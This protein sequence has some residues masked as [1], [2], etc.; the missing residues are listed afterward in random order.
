MGQDYY[1]VLGVGRDATDDQIKKAYKRKALQFH[2]DKNKAEDSEEKFKKI[3]EAYE[4]LSDTNKRSVY[5][6]YGEQGL[7]QHGSRNGTYTNSTFHPSDPFD[8]FRRFFGD[9]D[10]FRDIFNSVFSHHAHYGSPQF[11]K[12]H[13]ISLD[14]TY[15]PSARTTVEEHD[16]EGGTVHITKTIIGGDG[17]VRREMRFRTQSASRA[18]EEDR[19]KEDGKTI[20]GRQQSAPTGHGHGHVS[21]SIPIRLHS[22]R[23]VRREPEPEL[24]KAETEISTAT[25]T[26][27]PPK[28][29]PSP[30]VS[31]RVKITPTNSSDVK[32][33]SD[34]SDNVVGTK[35]TIPLQT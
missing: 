13:N 31:S 34:N 20:L 15:D 29:R 24:P 26:V 3:G 14:R 1:E 35:I 6:K 5:D 9:S 16:G 12:L 10:P 28:P 11:S 7:S 18:E 22:P 33:Q 19:R 4:V 2:P 23:T 30:T 27:T 32:K 25:I 8:L 17:R 21:T